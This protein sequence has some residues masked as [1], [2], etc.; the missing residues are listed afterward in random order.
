MVPP[1]SCRGG[2]TV[3][4]DLQSAAVSCC[5]GFAYRPLRGYRHQVL[6]ARR[7][8]VLLRRHVVHQRYQS[9][10]RLGRLEELRQLLR[11]GDLELP[12]NYSEL[13]LRVGQRDDRVHLLL[14]RTHRGLHRLRES[15]LVRARRVEFR[16]Q[17]AES[18]LDTPDE[19]LH[20]TEGLDCLVH[21]QQL[22]AQFLGFCC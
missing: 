16:R 2:F 9:L 11:G 15:S 21:V 12:I 17:R 19:S 13:F 8:P 22:L 5:N 3:A 6:L 1:A 4:V 20:P 14:R 10:Q 7:H 18:T